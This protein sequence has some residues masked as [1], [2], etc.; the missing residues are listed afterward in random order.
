[1]FKVRED[2]PKYALLWDKE[3]KQTNCYGDSIETADNSLN[4]STPNLL[5]EYYM[6][7]ES[8]KEK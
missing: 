5:H 8:L 1:M 4:S 2:E 7:D 6:I 3:T